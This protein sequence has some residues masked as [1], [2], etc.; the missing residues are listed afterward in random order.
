M[1]DCARVSCAGLGFGA[2]RCPGPAAA[3]LHHRGLIMCR[4][5]TLA[6]G[7]SCSVAAGP[8]SP[9]AAPQGPST[10][11]RSIRW[12]HGLGWDARKARHGAPLPQASPRRASRCC[13]SFA[14][15]SRRRPLP[16]LLPRRRGRTWAASFEGFCF[17]VFDR[18]FRYTLETERYACDGR[19]AC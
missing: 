3:F 16:P 5:P 17:V 4:S 11:V 10:V 19:A 8:T 7:L 1:C 12:V 14:V 9:A 15:H 6:G 2:S 13:F 18:T